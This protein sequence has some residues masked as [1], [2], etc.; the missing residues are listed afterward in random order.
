MK[1]LILLFPLAISLAY[2]DCSPSSLELCDYSDGTFY[3]LDNM[4]GLTLLGGYSNNT[5]ISNNNYSSSNAGAEANWDVLMTNGIWFSNKGM[6]QYMFSNIYTQN[7]YS[8]VSKL[9][10]GFQP[11][12]DYWIITPYINAG[13]GNGQIYNANST[14]WNLGLGLRTEIAFDTRDSVYGDYNY[15]FIMDGGNLSGTAGSSNSLGTVS[16]QPSVQLA[17]LGYKHVFDCSTN[18]QVFYR[19]TQADVSFS[20]PTQTS[21]LST[22]MIGVGITW[23]TGG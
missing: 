15:Q 10:Y 18:I 8:Y 17:E 4:F 7:T 19:Y 16:G 14:T 21:N 11:V 22:S 12:Y 3:H 6:Y 9:G 13:L 1:K 5:G 2:A 23:Y 20:Q